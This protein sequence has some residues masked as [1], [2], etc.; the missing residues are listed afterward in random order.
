MYIESVNVSYCVQLK[1]GLVFTLIIV[2]LQFYEKLIG[3][4][5]EITNIETFNRNRKKQKREKHK[6]IYF[7]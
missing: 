6:H 3:C 2:E 4:W 5:M 1:I 7:Q